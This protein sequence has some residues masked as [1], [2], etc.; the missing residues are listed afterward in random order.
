LT[1]QDDQFYEFSMI[2]IKNFFNESNTK[3]GMRIKNVNSRD[4]GIAEK[5]EMREDCI[6]ISFANLSLIWDL[7]ENKEVTFLENPSQFSNHKHY[8][9]T[10]M[11]PY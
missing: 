3:A 5:N 7:Y 6:Q 10:G 8:V 1:A 4:V 11:S 2:N 9:R